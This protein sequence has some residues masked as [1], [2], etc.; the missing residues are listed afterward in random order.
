MLDLAKNKLQR[1]SATNVGS[2][3]MLLKTIKMPHSI[4]NLANSLPKP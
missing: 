3:D 2:K 4:K 1:Y